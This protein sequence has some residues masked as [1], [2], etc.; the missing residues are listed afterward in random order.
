MATHESVENFLKQCEETL[1]AAHEQFQDGSLQEHY[2]DDVYTHAQARVEMT[3]NELERLK[4]SADG[5]QRYQLDRMRLRL[6]DIQNDM[7]LLDH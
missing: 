1:S 4:R 5:Q 3:V 2:N 6:Q 7:I